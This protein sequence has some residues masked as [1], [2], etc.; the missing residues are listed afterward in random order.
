MTKTEEVEYGEGNPGETGEDPVVI[1]GNSNFTALDV[2][3]LS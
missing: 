1:E 3:R 2:V